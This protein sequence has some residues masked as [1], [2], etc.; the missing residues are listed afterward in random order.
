MR[1]DHQQEHETPILWQAADMAEA[2]FTS[3]PEWSTAGESM[4]MRLSKF[5]LFNRLTLHELSNLVLLP[6]KEIPTNGVDLRRAD[7]FDPAR[8]GDLLAVSPT[9]VIAAFCYSTPGQPGASAE[10]RYCRECLQEGFH[11]AWFQWRFITRCPLHRRAL[12]LGCPGCARPIHYTLQRDMAEHPLACAQCGKQWVP[13]LYLPAGRC[14]PISGRPARILRRWQAHVAEATTRLS[15]LACRQHDPLTG[16]FVAAQRNRAASIR[17]TAHLRMSNRLYDT[18][19]PTI[20]ELLA[21]RPQPSADPLAP[22]PDLSEPGRP[23]FSQMNWPHFTQRFLEL[24][25]TLLQFQDAFFGHALRNIDMPAWS[26][27]CR[28]QF[29]IA[30]DVVSIETVTAVGWHLSWRGFARTCDRVHRLS[31]PAL[32]LSGWL[33]HSPDRPLA[34]AYAAWTDQLMVWLQ[35]DL[36]TSAW[37]WHRLASFMRPHRSY[38]LHPALARPAELAAWRSS[39]QYRHDIAAKPP[40]NLAIEGLGL[41]ARLD[42]FTSIMRQPVDK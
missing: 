27:L 38:L 33:A 35:E 7:R 10:L 12:R 2:R 13:A 23:R 37:I 21:R 24:E 1:E 31:T 18:P 29:A 9:D 19:P 20:P 34:I 32:G 14:T 26:T 40:Q 15:K 4:W 36:T 8:L 5:S 41:T 11:A 6:L 42:G 3:R 17:R 30:T 25:S 22:K 28:Q 39:Q 16:Q